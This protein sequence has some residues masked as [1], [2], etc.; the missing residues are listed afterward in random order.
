MEEQYVVSE[1]ESASS[2]EESFGMTE[3]D[4]S[5]SPP[6]STPSPKKEEP[7][8]IRTP[9]SSL[10]DTAPRYIPDNPIPK[11]EELILPPP[12]KS[13]ESPQST[14]QHPLKTNPG[15]KQTSPVVHDLLK[16]ARAEIQTRKQKKMNKIMDALLKTGRITN[17]EVQRL[18]RVSNVTA[19]RYLN[20]LEA[21]GTLEQVGKTGKAV[22]YRLR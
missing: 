13:T 9:K 10:S 16:K 8:I 19:F 6:P 18:L 12:P 3:K 17:R 2:F 15:L 14:P 21:E 4:I 20:R 7:K 5:S 1:N 22:F 11:E